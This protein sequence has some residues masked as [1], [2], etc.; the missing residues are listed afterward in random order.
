[1]LPSFYTLIPLSGVCL[2]I[3]FS[4]KDEIVTRI[5]SNKVFVFFG[6]I[7][8]SLYLF[9]YPIF[10]FS[11]ALEIFN[12]Y[13]KLLFIFLTIIISVFSYYFVEQP[14]RDKKIISFKR[15]VFI[16]SSF[17][18]FLIFFSIYIVK[19]DGLKQRLP[20]IFQLKPFESNI[21]FYQ[22]ENLQKVV[23]LGDSHSE[24]L[25]YYLNEELKK[26][27]LS[28]FRFP[29]A[30]YIK[31]FNK[32]D[33]KTKQINDNFVNTNNKIDKFLK[34]NSNLIVV[35]SHHWTLRI[36][37]TW[38]DNEEGHKQYESEED[39]FYNFFVEPI[40]IKTTNQQQREK[41]I[42]EGL[43]SEIN[44]IVNQGHK[45]ILVYPV[46][47]M[48]FDPYK[49][50]YSEYVKSNIF[51]KKQ[52]TPP[53]LT[54]SYD[55]FKKRSKKIFEILDSVQSPNIYRVYPH[56]SFCNT[57][58]VNRCV[59]NDKENMFYYDNNHLS[60]EG[61]KYVINDIMIAIQE[62]KVNKK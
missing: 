2:I 29:T 58:I 5:L 30:L 56:K 34:Y 35:F 14:F 26:N 20:K 10:A 39:K 61:S 37:E 44:N 1:M 52:F 28:L 57:T 59:A 22:K 50:L 46:P 13:Y 11:R 25:E 7:S 19:E 41:Y 54:G 17:I 12:D 21:K 60:L 33:K 8:Y 62:I 36:L 24:S 48:G 15:L 6:L 49:L 51:S 9:H 40:D 47:E 43:I 18:I 23:L 38:F 31:N 53:I 55:V 45:L 27:D 16:L 3:F 32:V 4:N 42:S